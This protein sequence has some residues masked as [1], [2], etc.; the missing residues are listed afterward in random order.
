MSPACWKSGDFEAQFPSALQR[1]HCAGTVAAPTTAGAAS[2]WTSSPEGRAPP[3]PARSAGGWSGPMIL[4]MLPERHGTLRA[5]RAGPTTCAVANN[6]LRTGRKA[7]R[8]CRQRM[9][10]EALSEGSGHCDLAALPRGLA[11]MSGSRGGT[12]GGRR[13]C[14]VSHRAKT[15]MSRAR[16]KVAAGGGVAARS[17]L[18]HCQSPRT[19][20]GCPSMGVHASRPGRGRRLARADC[21]HGRGAVVKRGGHKT[22]P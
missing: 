6:P 5:V 13:R 8:A 19:G 20:R 16:T 12:G 2:A 3:P 14:P 15:G 7:G 10:T 4:R 17:P 22:R 9:R 21:G 11:I 1:W 18:Q